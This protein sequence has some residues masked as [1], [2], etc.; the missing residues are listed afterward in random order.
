MKKAAE[1]E[2]KELLRQKVMEEAHLKKQKMLDQRKRYFYL[3]IYPYKN[4]I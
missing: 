4:E 1:L 3:C 2:R